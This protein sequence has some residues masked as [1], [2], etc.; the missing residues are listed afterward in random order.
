MESVHSDHEN[1]IK[2]LFIVQDLNSTRI[3]NF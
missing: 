3:N 2:I 1:G